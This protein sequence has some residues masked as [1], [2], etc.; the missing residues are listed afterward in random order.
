MEDLGNT[1]GATIVNAMFADAREHCHV[2]STDATGAAIKP[3]G[4]PDKRCE[5]CKRGHFFVVVADF[6]HVL[7]Q[8]TESH[9]SKTVESL[10]SGFSGYLQA[11]ASSVYDI[12]ERG[13]PGDTAPPLCLVEC[14]AN[15][16]R[17]FF[18][19]AITK[20]PAAVE[21]LHQIREIYAIDKRLARH[22]PLDRQRCRMQILEPAIDR[23]FKWVDIQSGV[24]IG[25]TTLSQAIGYAKNQESELRRVLLDGRLLLDN[26]RSEREFRRI[27]IGRENWL[28]YGSDTHAESAVAIFSILGSCRLHRIDPQRYLTEVLRLL[29]YWPRER[30]IELAPARWLQTRARLDDVEMSSP[31]CAITVPS[32]E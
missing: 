21:G 26:N 18:N 9:S 31:L 10:F 19:A 12:L 23:F 24:C 25:R 16:R 29:P 13:P 7:Y 15:C 32:V 20:H 4:R 2:L 5:A 28:F 27:V 8:Y 6:D 11:D 30:Y 14:W 22:G 17:Y 1:L 3:I